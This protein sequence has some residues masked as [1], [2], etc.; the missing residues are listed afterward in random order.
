[1]FIFLEFGS[2]SI[3]NTFVEPIDFVNCAQDKTCSTSLSALLKTTVSMLALSDSSV[4]IKHQLAR[5]RRMWPPAS[6]QS[7]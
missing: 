6:L 3:F 2:Q 1:M 4:Q 5:A 7:A